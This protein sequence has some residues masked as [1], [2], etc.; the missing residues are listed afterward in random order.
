[1]FGLTGFLDRLL[2][3]TLMYNSWK[4]RKKKV[5]QNTPWL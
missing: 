1:L 4:K 5:I 2:A 3:R